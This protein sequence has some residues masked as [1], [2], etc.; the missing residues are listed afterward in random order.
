MNK[1]LSNI[2]LNK[3]KSL[4]TRIQERFRKKSTGYVILNIS[5]ET[6]LKIEYMYG[7]KYS[8]KKRTNGIESSL[9]MLLDINKL[10]K[11]ITDEKAKTKF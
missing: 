6:K 3:N 5:A 10:V 9:G 8:L 2:S 1:E 7:G 11:K 4:K